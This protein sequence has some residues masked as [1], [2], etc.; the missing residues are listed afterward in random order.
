MDESGPY[1]ASDSSKLV[2]EVFGGKVSV[3]VALTKL[4]TRLLD[5]TLRNKLLN[6]RPPKGRAFQF[7]GGFDFDLLF[8]R[9]KEGEAVSLMY[10]PDPPAGRYENGKKPD[11]RAFA[12]ELGITTSFDLA[13]SIEAARRQ[14]GQ[15]L[16]VL[17]YPAD[18]ERM[19]RK[20]AGEAHTV[21]EETGSNMLYGDVPGV[22]GTSGGGF[23]R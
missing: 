11:V 19:A 16:Q 15:M 9:L 6:Y 17:L 5:L 13:R 23:R 1:E 4:R 7:T 10:V 3:E 12:K 20:V 14:R 22:V 21:I 2:D 8:E 18:L